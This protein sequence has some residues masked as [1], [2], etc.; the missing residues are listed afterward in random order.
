MTFW[1][2][3]QTMISWRITPQR[4][5][6]VP[7]PQ[8]NSLFKTNGSDFKLIH[9]GLTLEARELPDQTKLQLNTFIFECLAHMG[10]FSIIDLIPVFPFSFFVPLSKPISWITGLQSFKNCDRI[11]M[12]TF[13]IFQYWFLLHTRLLVINCI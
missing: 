1:S 7:L 6:C 12:I 2:P 13:Y 3:F 5:H 11:F 8:N 9:L 4:R 10:G